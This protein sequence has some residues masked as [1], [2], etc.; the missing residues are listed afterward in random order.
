MRRTI[1]GLPYTAIHTSAAF[2]DPT[3]MPPRILG[4]Y[5]VFVPRADDDGMS[6][7]GIRMLALAV[8]RAS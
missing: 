3:T 2:T 7:A 6:I 1:P 5:P 8:P 4:T